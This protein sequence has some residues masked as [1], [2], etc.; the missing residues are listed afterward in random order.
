M[1]FFQNFQFSGRHKLGINFLTLAIECHFHGLQ[2][3]SNGAC[4]DYFKEFFIQFHSKFAI[5]FLFQTEFT[6]VSF[7]LSAT[8][9]VSSLAWPYLFCYCA[10][11]VSDRVVLVGA[12]A[13]NS[14][15]YN[16]PTEWHKYI[17]L[18][19]VRSQESIAL[20]GFNL[21]PC[22]LQSFAKVNSSI[23]RIGCFFATLFM[24]LSFYFD[25]FLS[26]TN[27]FSRPIQY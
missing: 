17:L 4:N 22:S 20:T 11:Y 7:A 6:F 24:Y 25:R 1:F 3:L 21:V 19:I 16:Y 26:I 8:Y 27:Q 13:Y 14:N 9:I 2:F 23:K 18:V 15:W 5:C 10:T 12:T